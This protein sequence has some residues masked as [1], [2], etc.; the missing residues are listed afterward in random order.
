MADFKKLVVWQ[1]AH[2]LMLAVHE[3]TA[4]LR[5]PQHAA[6]RNQLMRAALSIPTNIV[7]GRGQKSDREF[8]RFLSYSLNSTSEVEYHLIAG[9]DTGAIREATVLAVLAKVIEVRRMLHGLIASLSPP[10]PPKPPTAITPEQED[11]AREVD[12]GQPAESSQD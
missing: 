7:E 4:K 1:K 11:E 8:A 6:L 10:T 2:E 12:G 9:R 3:V 5:G